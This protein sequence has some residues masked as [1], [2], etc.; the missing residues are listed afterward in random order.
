MIKKIGIYFIIFITFLIAS[1]LNCFLQMPEIETRKIEIK[2][3]NIEKTKTTVRISWITTEESNCRTSIEATTFHTKGK[4]HS[5]FI[6][7]LNPGN[8]YIFYIEAENNESDI[9]M[10]SAYHEGS[11]ITDDAQSISITDITTVDSSATHITMKWK[12]DTIANCYIEYGE[13]SSYGNIKNSTSSDLLVHEV[14]L[15]DLIGNKTYH[16][17]IHA[18]NIGIGWLS[19]E[20][21]ERTFFIYGD[22]V[23]ISNETSTVNLAD[24]TITCNTDLESNCRVEYSTDS[25]FSN[26]NYQDMNTTD[27]LSHSVTMEDLSSNVYY[28]RIRAL[29]INSIYSNGLSDNLFFLIDVT[30]SLIVELEDASNIDNGIG[31][32]GN[33]AN[34]LCNEYSVPLIESIDFKYDS[35]LNFEPYDIWDNRVVGLFSTD[36]FIRIVESGKNITD[37]TGLSLTPIAKNLYINTLPPQSNQCFI[38]PVRGK[39]MLPR[40]AFW[41]RMESIDNITSAEIY[42]DSNHS[43]FSI[44]KDDTSNVIKLESIQGKFSN[45]IRAY[46]STDDFGQETKFYIYPF[47]QDYQTPDKGTLSVWLKTTN[48]G[49]DTISFLFFGELVGSH[50]LCIYIST[51][52]DEGIWYSSSSIKIGGEY[53]TREDT[54]I[55]P[56]PNNWNHVYIVWDRDKNMSEGRSVRL[57]INGSNK[58]NSQDL[59]PSFVGSNLKIFLRLFCMHRASYGYVDNLKIWTHVVSEDPA[60][61]YNNG[62]GR[63]DSLHFIYGAENGYRPKLSDSGSGV[64][65]F[66]AQ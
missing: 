3:I 56:Y 37:I 57:W 26:Y 33:P 43:S 62:D 36:K 11:F 16:Y 22:P 44:F 66:H 24:V 55:E 30:D 15:T 34:V 17:K 61:I 53:K 7:G 27:H 32:F 47:G 25:T 60:W 18:E 21:T 12:T 58:L 35:P 46:L 41:S 9:Y 29:P 65:Y 14:T 23:V 19:S 4:Q 8:H 2:N 64:G 51:Q 6:S 54:G 40:P 42:N 45:C 59:I 31:T 1:N 50:P 13:N 49:D 52:Y 48:I 63:E 28:Y 38:D 10:E 39:F 20:T 5:V